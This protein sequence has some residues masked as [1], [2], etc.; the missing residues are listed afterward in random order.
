MI[1]TAS[2]IRAQMSMRAVSHTREVAVWP[3]PGGLRAG[4]PVG[5][6]L[7]RANHPVWPA[8]QWV[9]GSPNS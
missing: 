6:P 5:A 9:K 1:N 2:A 3:C 7:V 4:S 8:R